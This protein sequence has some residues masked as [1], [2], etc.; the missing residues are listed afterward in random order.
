[1]AGLLQLLHQTEFFLGKDPCKHVAIFQALAIRLAQDFSGAHPITDPN[2]RGDGASGDQVVAGH[3]ENAH[4]EGAQVLDHR[5]GI[6]ARRIFQRQQPGHLQFVPCAGS[7]RQHT[8]TLTTPAKGGETILAF[9]V[10]CGLPTTA[11]VPGS[12][13]QLG[14][15]PQT[16]NP[17]STQCFIGMTPAGVA[18]AT[19]ISPGLY[20][21]NLVV[22]SNASHGD[23]LIYCSYTRP[24]FSF[25]TPPRNLITVL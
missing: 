10:G 2:L 3:H 7:D 5:L 22:P 24:G 23:N 20:Q 25:F 6:L 13:T 12:S 4:P 14:P 17:P 19:L 15:L 21:F 11:L 8:I 18:A 1:V 16:Q 9:A